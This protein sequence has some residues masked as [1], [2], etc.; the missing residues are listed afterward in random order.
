MKKIRSNKYDLL[1]YFLYDKKYLSKAYI[2]HVEKFFNNIIM[3]YNNINNNFKK[4][5]KIFK[6]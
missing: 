4:L 2:N 6:I 1:N 3:Y 5:I